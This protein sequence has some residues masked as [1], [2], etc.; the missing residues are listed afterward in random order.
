MGRRCRWTSGQRCVL[1]RAIKKR[2]ESLVKDLG[3]TVE[4]AE[5][6]WAGV[7]G[8]DTHARRHDGSL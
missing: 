5:M 7:L 8:E 3:G 1:R 4:V 2:E 6:N